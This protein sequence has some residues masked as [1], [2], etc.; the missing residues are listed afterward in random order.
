MSVRFRIRTPGGQELSFASQDTF[1]DF[2]RSGDLSPD[3]LVYDAADGSWAPARTHPIVLEIEYED[4][5]NDAQDP[6]A[7]GETT[8]QEDEGAAE[9]SFGLSLADE[10]EAPPEEV[11]EDTASRAPDGGADLGLQLAMP[12]EVSPEEAKRAFVQRMEAERASEFEFDVGDD[13]LSGFKMETSGS[14][15]DMVPAAPETKQSAPAPTPALAPRQPARPSRSGGVGGARA[16]GSRTAASRPSEGRGGGGGKLLGAAVIVVLLAGGGW[17]GL[18]LGRQDVEDPSPA[19]ELPVEA[20]PVE[21]APEPEP[22]RGPV[23]ARTPAAVRERARERFLT[24]TQAEL[25][26][27]GPIPESWPGGSYLALPSASPEVLD[28]WQ[29]YLTTIRRVR[30]AD[31]ARY[32]AAYVTALDDAV[33]E[34]DEREV[35]LA[36]AMVEFETSAEARN[37]H[38]DRVESLASAAIQSHN[39]LLDVE[40]LLIFSGSGEGVAPGPI[41]AGVT[42][43]DEDSELLPRQVAELLTTT[44]EADGLGPGSGDNV[45]AWVWDGFLD[46]AA[47]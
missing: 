12:E 37:A 42:A 38:Y 36:S 45:R 3:D 26:A 43:R 34:G 41:G 16:S 23:I 32:R 10:D 18:Q 1:E 11:L 17:F 9:D 6:G 31:V 40:G 33:I 15:A 5:T 28:S 20:I 19:P 22:T 24:A 2:V 47:N 8:P 35:R 27:L 44:L 30:A 46:A 29:A 7:Q 14:L 21:P 25:R 13:G 4:D 39:A